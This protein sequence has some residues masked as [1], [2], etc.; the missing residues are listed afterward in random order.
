[1]SENKKSAKLVE[2]NNQ[3]DQDQEHQ[4]NNEEDEQLSGQDL[5]NFSK[6]AADGANTQR[7]S[8]LESEIE[9][10]MKDREYKLALEKLVDLEKMNQSK[11]VIY[12]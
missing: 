5:H 3:E 9:N 10:A 11:A 2:S 7:E 8:E 4:D 1:M 12:L 6:D